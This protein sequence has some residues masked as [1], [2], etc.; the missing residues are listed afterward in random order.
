MLVYLDL[1][2]CINIIWFNIIMVSIVNK[3]LMMLFDV[4]RVYL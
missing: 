2:I 1:Y 4:F 3:I